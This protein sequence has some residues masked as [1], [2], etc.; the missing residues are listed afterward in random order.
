MLP[1]EDYIRQKLFINFIHKCTA[2]R[3][4]ER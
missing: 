2:V 3:W 4:H 1:D